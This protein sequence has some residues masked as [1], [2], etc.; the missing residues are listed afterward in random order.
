MVLANPTMAV[1]VTMS[2]GLTAMLLL[3]VVASMRKTSN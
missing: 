2:L 1:T 3:L